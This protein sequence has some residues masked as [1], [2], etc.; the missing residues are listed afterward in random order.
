MNN[1][2]F[3]NAAAS[4]GGSVLCDPLFGVLTFD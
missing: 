1:L 2:H 4:C 3:V